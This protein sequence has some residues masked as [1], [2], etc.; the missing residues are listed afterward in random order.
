MKTFRHSGKEPE[1]RRCYGFSTGDTVVAIMVGADYGRA[2]ISRGSV[3]KG[4]C[5]DYAVGEVGI[6]VNHPNRKDQISIQSHRRFYL[7]PSF[8]NWVRVRR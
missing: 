4:N 1:T 2:N 8:G 5:Y 7:Q 6:V 3:E